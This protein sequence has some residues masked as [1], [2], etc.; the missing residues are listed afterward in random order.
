MSPKNSTSSTSSSND[1]PAHSSAVSIH[2][3]AFNSQD[4][5][6][7]F[8][9][10]EMLFDINGCND[11]GKRFTSVVVALG[12]QE[13]AEMRDV[14]INRPA[15]SPYTTLKM[16]LQKRIGASQQK[17][18]MQLLE[19]EE[20]GDRKPSQFVRHLRHLD[21]TA[22]DSILRSLLLAA[23]PA[24]LQSSLAPFLNRSL[25]DLL[26]FADCSH[27]AFSREPTTR[28]VVAA[29]TSWE[30]DRM[31]RMENSLSML[32]KEVADLTQQIRELH[33]A[34]SRQSRFRNRSNS[35]PRSKSKEPGVCWY[36]RKFGNKS[37]RCTTPCTFA[38]GNDAGSR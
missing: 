3:P 33:T 22:S 1:T 36:H 9:Q 32:Q 13:A 37:T 5:E 4:L 34:S 18:T 29:T 14:I 28:H 30:N 10:V 8:A 26:E 27:D 21:P 16:E 12:P 24:N 17:K 6:L 31:M 19:R 23:M 20:L 38:Q 35:Q 7:W 15:T 11:E 25:E 2:L